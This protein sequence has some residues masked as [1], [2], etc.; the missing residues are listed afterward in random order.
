MGV[1]MKKL[2]VT[3]SILGIVALII[4]VLS[5]WFKIVIYRADNPAIVVVSLIYRPINFL[6]S[7]I[8]LSLPMI[9]LIVISFY[10]YFKGLRN[11][12]AKYIFYASMLV[13]VSIMYF[14][15]YVITTIPSLVNAELTQLKSKYGFDYAADIEILGGPIIAVFSSIFG[16]LVAIVENI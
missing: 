16:A 7:L 14:I 13:L 3:F 8:L 9:V 1:E 4:S 6:V 11:S 12:E 15:G 10:L 2:S 5:P